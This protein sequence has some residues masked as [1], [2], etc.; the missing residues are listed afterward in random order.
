MVGEGLDLAVLRVR[1]GAVPDGDRL[2]FSETVFPVCSPALL[3]DGKLEERP[4]HTLLQEHHLASPEKEWSTWL[5]LLGFGSAAKVTIVRY[6][7]FSA[8]LA[9]AVAGAGIALGRRPLIDFELES[10]RLVRPFGDQ[11]L[12]GS[13][14]MIIRTRP[15]AARDVHVAHLLAF[16][17]QTLAPATTPA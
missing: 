15:G 13:S 14:D 4:R 7:S 1:R 11:S 9:A 12:P 10:G 3:V 6:Y 2:L 5:D 8:A 16:L 17:L